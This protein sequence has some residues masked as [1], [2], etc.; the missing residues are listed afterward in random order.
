MYV[1]TAHQVSHSHSM[2]ASKSRGRRFAVLLGLPGGLPVCL[3]VTIRF[4]FPF[5]H[6]ALSHLA[7]PQS[8]PTTGAP[9]EIPSHQPSR[10]TIRG[11]PPRMDDLGGCNVENLHTASRFRP[12]STVGESCEAARREPRAPTTLV[13]LHLLTP[14]RPKTPVLVPSF[15]ASLNCRPRDSLR[16]EEGLVRD[17]KAD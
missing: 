5:R 7:T 1:N 6:L 15:P 9:K 14:P 17:P 11:G 2:T 12:L 10:L 4:A 16:G 3:A 13:Q 8:S